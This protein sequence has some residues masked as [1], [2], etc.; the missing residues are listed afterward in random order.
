MTSGCTHA[1]TLP[2]DG[3][4]FIEGKD[5]RGVL[6]RSG[7]DVQML[8]TIWAE[9]DQDRRGKVT[10]PAGPGLPLL[11]YMP[12]CSPP[13]ATRVLRRSSTPTSLR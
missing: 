12:L 7:L 8:G 11:C 10:L 4:G 1:Q 5:A 3:E 2:A 13:L 6:M 9:V